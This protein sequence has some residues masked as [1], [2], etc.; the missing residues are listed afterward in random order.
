MLFTLTLGFSCPLL[1][2]CT[3]DSRC[4]IGV[5]KLPE[6][7]LQIFL[8]A[9]LT[10]IR[11]DALL[12]IGLG[13]FHLTLTSGES[14]RFDIFKRVLGN[15]CGKLI[16]IVLLILVQKVIHVESQGE[17]DSLIQLFPLPCLHI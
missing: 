13:L 9:L 14:G 12:S 1:S 4:D 5:I 8:K 16:R 3:L 2:G 11:S 17:G 6:L 10:V 7:I 15:Q